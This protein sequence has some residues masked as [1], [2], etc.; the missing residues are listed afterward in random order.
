ME[1]P[2]TGV[3]TTIELIFK[4]LQECCDEKTTNCCLG[5]LRMSVGFSFF[6][7]RQRLCVNNHARF[8]PEKRP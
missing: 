7:R 8:R 4:L 6:L 2:V 5:L 3:Y 1:Y